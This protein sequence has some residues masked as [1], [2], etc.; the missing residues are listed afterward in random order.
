MQTESLSNLESSL[1][2]VSLPKHVAI[3]M[4]GN[5]RWAKK[6]GLSPFNGHWKGEET[7]SEIVKVAQRLGIKVLTVYT[8]ST[9][10]WLRS[11][12]EVEMHMYL[13]RTCLVNRKEQMKREGVKLDVIG[14]LTKLSV[15][16]K[17][18]LE[19]IKRETA[20]CDQINLVLAIN[21]GGRDDIRRAALSIV[22]ECL[23]GNLKKEEISEEIFASYLDTAPWGDPDLLIRTSGEMRLS[24]FLLWQVSYAEVY[25]TDVLW[26][27]FNESEFIK[28]IVEY[29]RRERRL[30]GA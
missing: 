30:G 11:H 26:P 9:E 10:N 13:L 27:D 8:F 16:M 23:R 22:E 2:A 7:L 1:S 29:Q 18:I 12:E 6:R 19:E 4:D 28:A 17:V 25:V 15:S 24:N 20:H 5:R 14:D 3:I 21:Y